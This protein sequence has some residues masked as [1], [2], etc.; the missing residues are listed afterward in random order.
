MRIPK[1]IDVNLVNK[2][3]RESLVGS[4]PL[5]PAVAE[6]FLNLMHYLT[7]V[8]EQ[9]DENTLK[10]KDAVP[11]MTKIL[12]N[13]RVCLQILQDI[14]SKNLSLLKQGKIK[15]SYEKLGELEKTLAGLQITL[16][17]LMGSCSTS[18]ALLRKVRHGG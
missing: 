11:T 3:I 6:E 15:R 4:G 18:H 2:T 8:A 9:V 1:N 10:V 17:G 7:D 12:Q 16:N 5:R 13:Q 14:L